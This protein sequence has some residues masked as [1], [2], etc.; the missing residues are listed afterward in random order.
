MVGS[1]IPTF[2][3]MFLLL[4]KPVGSGGS[5]G[6]I[7]DPDLFES[8]VLLDKVVGSGRSRGGIQDPNLFESV[9]FIA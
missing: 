1:R 8:Q 9:V 7:Q 3:T 5:R 4:H 2:S 6:G